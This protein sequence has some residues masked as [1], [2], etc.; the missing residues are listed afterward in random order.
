MRK[1]G[2]AE[3]DE[4]QGIGG[5]GTVYE[6]SYPS[7]KKVYLAPFMA[8]DGKS[9][10][11]RMASTAAGARASINQS[12]GKELSVADLNADWAMAW[13]KKWGGQTETPT[14][15][16]DADTGAQLFPKVAQIT[17]VSTSPGPTPVT[18]TTGKNWWDQMWA[19]IS[20]LIGMK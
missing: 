11:A 18:V 1:R 2:F 3:R 6:V 8:S 5:F 14:L 4:F 12:S 15:V 19:D 13:L 20:K 16:R 9:R 7:G 17:I 10:D